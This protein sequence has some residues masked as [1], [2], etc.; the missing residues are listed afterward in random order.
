MPDSP[1]KR[2]ILSDPNVIKRS[3]ETGAD[4][5]NENTIKEIIFIAKKVITNKQK[6]KT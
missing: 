4:L 2:Q 6:T 1:K 5:I 3:Y